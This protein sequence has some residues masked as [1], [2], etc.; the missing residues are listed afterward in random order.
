MRLDIAG[1][2]NQM[3][4]SRT[5]SARKPIQQAAY[6]VQTATI[7]Q[8]H[9]RYVRMGETA[10]DNGMEL[11]ARARCDR[12]LKPN[13]SASQPKTYPGTK[14]TSVKRTKDAEVPSRTAIMKFSVM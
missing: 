13:R 9:S 14:M 12:R 1:R 6:S 4:R 11:A 7:D 10:T 2:E 8:C 5:K 3:R